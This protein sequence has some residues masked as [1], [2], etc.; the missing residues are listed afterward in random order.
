MNKKGSV[1]SFALDSY[2][3]SCFTVGS[4]LEGESGW[5]SFCPPPPHTAGHRHHTDHIS[6]CGYRVLSLPPH[7]WLPKEFLLSYC[8]Y[9]LLILFSSVFISLPYPT[10]LSLCILLFFG[11]YVYHS[12]LS[13]NLFSYHAGPLY[14]TTNSQL[15]RNN[16]LYFLNYIVLSLGVF[17]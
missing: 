17:V 7:L 5:P 11:I 14:S 8:M 2:F 3:F 15:S 10:P 6:T 1:T 13:S 4:H 9:F 12:T 16:I